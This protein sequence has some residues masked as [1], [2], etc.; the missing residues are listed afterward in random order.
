MR[1]CASAGL[2]LLAAVTLGSARG[3]LPA[4]VDVAAGVSE[5]RRRRTVEFLASDDCEGRGPGSAGSARAVAWLEE[6][7]AELGLEPLGDVG[8][9]YRQHVPLRVSRVLPGTTL[10]LTSLGR[11]WTP[12][13]GRDYLLLAS[14]NQTE[15]PQA[16]PLV[17]VGWGI[18]APEFDHDDYAGV[19][20]RGRAVVYLEGE[21][22][23][24]DPSWFGGPEPTV[25]A[26]LETKQ[27]IALAHG[28]VASVVLPVDRGAE[29]G[30]D[31]RA[32]A[33][34]LPHVQPAVD[35]PRH[36]SLVLSPAWVE[37]L[38]EDALYGLDQVTDMAET[39][40]LRSFHLPWS[41]RFSGRFELRTMLEPNLV[42]LLPGGDRRLG[43]TA[44][45]LSAHWDHLGRGPAVAGD[46]IY[47]GAV[48]N[49]LGVA[50][51]LEVMRVLAGLERPLRR[52]VVLLLTAAEEGGLL[53]ARHFLERPPMPLA[54]MVAN[55]NVDGLAFHAD[56]R[57]VI[58]VGGELSD[59][60][61]W[62]A[63]VAAPLG[64]GVAT[65]PA[66]IWSARAF[67]FS[68]QVAFA[69]RGIP[70]VLVNEG[71]D[72]PG[73]TRQAAVQRSQSWMLETY[74]S[75]ADDLE[76]PI[77]WQAAA[78]HSGLIAA[79]VAVLADSRVAPEWRA[80]APYA[81]QRQLS[82]AREPRR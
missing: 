77:H 73:W 82:R 26:E 47:N 80:G 11:S 12:E 22:P 25:Y 19:D 16:T 8:G 40:T 44:V 52:S 81:Y 23:S 36:L 76:Q 41:L 29:E 48:D 67:S 72:W 69:E 10:E 24:Q 27:R 38:F 53:G 79:L 5:Q 68:D 33:Y 54:R 37:R 43:E 51:A 57:D 50:G 42:A 62:V 74:H 66:E 6:R 60:G 4:L 13:L 70:A 32:A 15:V 9:G 1:W 59:L 39:A 55:V 56:F 45:V 61:A 71:F 63:R 7:L 20:V 78:R 2:V 18:K 30:W 34:A 28:A 17:F 65:P 75:P 14:G 21:P 49:A 46:E 64:L 35:L 58:A 3:R 31:R